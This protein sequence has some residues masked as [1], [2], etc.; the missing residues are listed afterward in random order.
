MTKIVMTPKEYAEYIR[1][2]ITTLN[3]LLN[4]GRIPGAIRIGSRWRI[5]VE[6]EDK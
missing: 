2:H 1:I 3:Y 4:Q 5:R 6:E